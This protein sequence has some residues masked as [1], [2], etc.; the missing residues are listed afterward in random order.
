MVSW[1]IRADFTLYILSRALRVSLWLF[2]VVTDDFVITR[3][4]LGL[5]IEDI[6]APTQETIMLSSINLFKVEGE[7]NQPY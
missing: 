3:R 4:S 5:S 6:D 2:K 7:L 1:Q